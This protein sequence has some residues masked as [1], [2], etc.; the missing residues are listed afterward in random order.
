LKQVTP[1]SPERELQNK[2]ATFPKLA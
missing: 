1:R 2:V